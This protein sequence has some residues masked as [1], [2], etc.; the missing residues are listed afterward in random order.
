M[1]TL[2]EDASTNGG[3]V[4]ELNPTELHSGGTPLPVF[5][6]E[7]TQLPR[8]DTVCASPIPQFLCEP[9]QH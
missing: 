8:A 9:N 3:G 4:P 1:N 2:Y 5:L 6:K 7:V